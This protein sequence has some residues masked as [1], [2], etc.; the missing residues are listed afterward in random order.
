MNFTKWF[1]VAILCTNGISKILELEKRKL[2][3]FFLCSFFTFWNCLHAFHVEI[4]GR[5]R[6]G[7]L[8]LILDTFLVLMLLFVKK[9]INIY[10]FKKEF[11]TV[12]KCVKFT[13][14]LGI[15][16]ILKMSFVFL[17]I[18]CTVSKH[19]FSECRFCIFCSAAFLKTHIHFPNYNMQ[20]QKI[21]TYLWYPCLSN[22]VLVFFF[23]YINQIFF[24][25]FFPGIVLGKFWTPSWKS[26]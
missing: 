9:Y 7:G 5:S 19:I 26:I 18:L 10:L 13:L 24:S 25:P 3:K 14:I 22:D 12:L 4:W 15:F 16:P 6:G 20:K 21:L 1:T 17:K 2:E 8:P 11:P 23:K